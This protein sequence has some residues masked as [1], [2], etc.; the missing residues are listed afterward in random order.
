LSDFDVPYLL[1]DRLREVARRFLDKYHSSRKIPIPIEEIIEFQM[2]FNIIPM[3]GL[4]V[5][6]DAD[7]V[8]GFTSSDLKDITVDEWIWKHRPGRYR[9]TL[10]HEVGH[11]ILHRHLYESVRFST[12]QG[13]K[14]FINS[15]PDKDHA[16]YE[17]QAYAFAGLVLVPDGPLKEIVDKHMKAILRLLK[18][19]NIS[20]SEAWES[21]WD[22]I[23]ELAAKDFEVSPG[24]IQK[25]VAY[26]HLQDLYRTQQGNPAQSR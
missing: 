3:P 25:R 5:T 20:P 14:T 11:I 2:G 15:I 12:I 10:A 22:Q 18:K 4:Q 19:D 8:L 23:Y 26:D 13:W 17:W 9:F 7:E 21:I 24:V 6:L 1:Y 16:R